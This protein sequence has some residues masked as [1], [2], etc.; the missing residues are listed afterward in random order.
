MSLVSKTLSAIVTIVI[1]TFFTIDVF[2]APTPVNQENIASPETFC[3]GA[4]VNDYW[5]V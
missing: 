4:K 1:F 2:A 3:N 5:Y